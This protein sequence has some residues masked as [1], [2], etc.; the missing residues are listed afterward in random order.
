M[1]RTNHM[2]TPTP[3]GEGV[4][5]LYCAHHLATQ[6]TYSHSPPHSMALTPT[7]NGTCPHP[8]L[9]L[10]PSSSNLAVFPDRKCLVI[11]Q[12]SGEQSKGDLQTSYIWSTMKHT[13]LITLILACTC[14]ITNTLLLATTFGYTNQILL[15]SGGTIVSEYH[16]STPTQGGRG[17]TIQ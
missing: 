14:L 4:V 8:H 1:Y 15:P 6:S 2:T 16:V 11:S 9:S 7:L 10:L 5:S 13:Y 17:F 12:R 3:I